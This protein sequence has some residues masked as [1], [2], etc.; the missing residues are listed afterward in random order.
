MANTGGAVFYKMKD[1]MGEPDRVMELRGRGSYVTVLFEDLL[2][3]AVSPSLTYLGPTYELS[4]PPW[5]HD[6]VR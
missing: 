5:Y 1:G 2:L 3:L 6:D 4:K